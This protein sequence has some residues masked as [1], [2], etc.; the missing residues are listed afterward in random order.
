MDNRY[1]SKVIAELNGLFEEQG[2]KPENGLFKNKTKA[3]KISYDEARQSYLLAAADIDEEGNV[4]DFAELSSWLFDDSQT[5]ADAEAVGIDFTDTLRKSLGLKARAVVGAAVELPTAEKG[6]SIKIAGFTKKVLDVYP[7]F[8]DSYKEHITKYGNFLYLHF[9]GE[10]LVLQIK[11]TMKQNNKKSRKKLFEM[12]ENAYINGD[13]E[14]V[15][16]AVSVLAAAAFND[17][18]VRAAI[19]EMLSPNLH[20]KTSFDNFL[21]VFASKKKLK[22]AFGIS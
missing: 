20:F 11:E 4:G 12:L 9:F 10:T 13:K 8:K 18:Q 15:N 14:T 6:T 21:P 7:Q 22:E 16:A 5:E 17:E 3:V 1:E 19:D 2:F